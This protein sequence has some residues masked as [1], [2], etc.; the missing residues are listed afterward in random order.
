MFESLN[1]VLGL[2]CS[3]VCKVTETSTC[4]Q[5]HSSLHWLPSRL[6]V[7]VCTH[8]DVAPECDLRFVSCCHLLFVLQPPFNDAARAKAG[9][10][11]EWYMPLTG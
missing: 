4:A 7:W 5:P 1:G 6:T 9:F 11:P 3:N 10:G 2:L 8:S